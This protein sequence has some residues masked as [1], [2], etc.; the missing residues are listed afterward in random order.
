MSDESLVRL[1]T[2]L[3]FLES[4]TAELGEEVYR[5]RQEISALRARLAALLDRL[6]SA[7]GP[8]NDGGNTHERPPHY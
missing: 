8:S 2:K 1:E 4:A 7:A 3:A 6:E 5:Q